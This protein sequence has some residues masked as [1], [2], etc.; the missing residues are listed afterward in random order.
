M[1][2][3]LF[4]CCEKVF[5]EKDNFYSHHNMEDFTDADYTH[6]KRC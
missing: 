6:Q 2:I 3:S 4:Y 5:P 1:S